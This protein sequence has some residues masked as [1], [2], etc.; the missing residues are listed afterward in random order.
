MGR[1]RLEG[2][3]DFIEDGEDYKKR[4]RSRVSEDVL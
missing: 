4:K 3:A 2:D 1:G